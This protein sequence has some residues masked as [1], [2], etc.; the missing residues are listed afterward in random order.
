MIICP[1]LGVCFKEL[2]SRLKKTFS[3]RMASN[4]VSVEE[5]VSLNSIDMFCL[6]IGASPQERFF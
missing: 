3:N 2:E 1:P 4:Q 5:V 6:K